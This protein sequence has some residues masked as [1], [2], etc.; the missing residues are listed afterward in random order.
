MDEA[1]NQGC[2]W[3]L[4]VF[5][6]LYRRRFDGEEEPNKGLGATWEVRSSHI[7]STVTQAETRSSSRC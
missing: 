2:D 6:E 4:M 7:G 3:V 5:D 1:A